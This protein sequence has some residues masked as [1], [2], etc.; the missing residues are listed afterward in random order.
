[1]QMSRKY[2]TANREETVH[3]GIK[4]GRVL[5][6]NS[7]VCITGDLGAGKTVISSGIA[8]GLGVETEGYITSPTFTL[9]NEYEGRLPLFHFD[10]YRVH[11][12]DELYEIGFSEYFNRGGVV[13]IEW[14]NLIEEIL[15]KD[16]I[17]IVINKLEKEKDKREIT[18]YGETDI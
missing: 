3:L 15:P 10:V 5:K 17:D 12:P 11:D 9:V 6:N 18:I 4:L 13:L 16:R 1:M 7:V 2:I 14:A 8:E